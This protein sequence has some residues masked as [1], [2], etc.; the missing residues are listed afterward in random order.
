FTPREDAAASGAAVEKIATPG[1]GSIEDVVAFLGGNLTASRMLKSLLFMADGAIAM[2]VVRGDHEVNEIA[3]A[4]TLGAQELRLATEEEVRAATGAALG[5]AGPVGFSGRVV[6]DREA[7]EVADAVTG[8]NETD[9]H[10]A[11]VNYGRDFE[12][13]VAALRL[14]G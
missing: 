8:A 6:I 12:A 14:V 3:V 13:E 9:V 1:K 2:A 5:F 10:L 11:N 7:A 4:R